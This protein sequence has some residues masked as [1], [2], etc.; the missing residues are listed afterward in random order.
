[1]EKTLKTLTPLSLL[2]R[3]LVFAGLGLWVLL[4]PGTLVGL[5]HL[6]C[7]LALILN[8]IPALFVSIFQR[9][10]PHP[11]A[12]LTG[13]VSLLLAVLLL[14][15][16]GILS[17][18]ITIVV[19]I[20]SMLVGVI[21]L[22]YIAQLFLTHERGKLRYAL[23][24]AI[25][26]ISAAV[27]LLSPRNLA[28]IQFYA[29]L[30][31][32]LYGL[33][34]L[35]DMVGLLVNR[36]VDDS[37]FLSR[38]RIKL[39][40]LI[41]ALLPAVWYRGLEKQRDMLTHDNVLLKQTRRAFPED[42]QLDIIF[43]LGKDVAFGFGHVDVSL[44]GQTIS[45]GCYDEASNRLLGLLSDGV[46]MTAP[47]APY[48]DYCRQVEGKLLV[49]FTLALSH[50]EGEHVTAAMARVLNA[51]QPW[52]P[53]G[54][55]EYTFGAKFYKVTTGKFAVYNALRTNCAAMAEIIATESGLALLP[56][57]GFV[58][59]GAYFDFLQQELRDAGSKVVK[60]TIYAK[61]SD[62]PGLRPE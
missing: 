8:G 36:N 32:L 6:I 2:I 35:I 52:Q 17:R 11:H 59:P 60:Q 41:T 31:L 14:C 13:V 25:S 48:L 58:S 39:P 27:L 4:S 7:V 42:E 40:V 10:E 20:W 5:M 50:D 26:L 43:H 1:M 22:G 21:Q 24:A 33:W 53:D 62:T 45:Y 38:I 44:R 3:F 51:C 23:F 56:P 37:R 9:K 12:L 34:Q 47:T 28:F 16:P 61:K 18:S 15:F 29:G 46:F 57:S 30:Y 55:P 54:R 49:G 19:G